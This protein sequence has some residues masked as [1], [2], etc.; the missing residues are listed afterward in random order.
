LTDVPKTIFG[1][2]SRGCCCL[3]I[4]VALITLAFTFVSSAHFAHPRDN[5]KDEGGRIKAE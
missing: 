3:N 1:S 2:H 5:R 4:A